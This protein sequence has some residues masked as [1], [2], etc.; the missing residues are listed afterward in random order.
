NA[1]T[2]ADPYTIIYTSGTTGPP[3]GCV[4]SHGNYR[5]VMNM[6]LER[7]VR[8]MVEDGVVYLFLPLAHAYALL[9][10]LLCVDLGT[11]LAYFGGDVKQVIPELQEVRPTY[12]PSVPRIFEKLYTIVT[13]PVDPATVA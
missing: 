11:T 5:D 8:G 3:K 1:V 4:L 6:V 7:G 9:I 2:P 12:L 10:Q 13:E